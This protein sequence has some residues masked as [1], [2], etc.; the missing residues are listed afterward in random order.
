LLN[1]SSIPQRTPTRLNATY[2]TAE[3]VYKLRDDIHNENEGKYELNSY[4]GRMSECKSHW[5]QD[6][7][8]SNLN[9]DTKLAVYEGSFPD[10]KRRYIKELW[11]GQSVI[12]IRK[13]KPFT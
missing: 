13:S 6:V 2:F 7:R 11:K 4:R 12:L 1:F 5:D 9:R 8:L 3:Q 10:R